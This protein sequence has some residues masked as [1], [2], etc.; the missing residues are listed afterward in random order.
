MPV[1]PSSAVS[2]PC[3]ML[4]WCLS[5]PVLHY[6][7]H[8]SCCTVACH[9][10]FWGILAMHHAALYAHSGGTNSVCL[11]SLAVFLFSRFRLF[12]RSSVRACNCKRLLVKLS[13]CISITICYIMRWEFLEL[14]SLRCSSMSSNGSCR[15]TLQHNVFIIADIFYTKFLNIGMLP[16]SE[17]YPV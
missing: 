3:I 12:D 9:S 4:H 10:Q 14:F 17:I 7:C 13:L 11:H 6:P 5:F 15:K 2:L 16:S 8:A 1:I